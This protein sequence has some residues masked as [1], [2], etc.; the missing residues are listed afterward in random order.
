MQPPPQQPDDAAAAFMKDGEQAFAAATEQ[1]VQGEAFGELLARIT[2]NAMALTKIAF[3]AGD[4]VV[5]G[6]RLAGRADVNRLSRQLGR[7]EDKLEMVLQEVEALRA[8]LGAAATPPPD[9][10]DPATP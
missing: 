4:A 8:Q 9:D 5:R 6:L 10:G 2:E 7:T 1:M 3:D